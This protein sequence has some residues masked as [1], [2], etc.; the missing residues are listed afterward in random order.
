[1]S[2]SFAKGEICISVSHCCHWENFEGEKRVGLF[3]LYFKIGFFLG[4]ILNVSNG[5]EGEWQTFQVEWE[6]ILG[7]GQSFKE[8][9]VIN[10]QLI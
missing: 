4:R 5:G 1:M 3:L 6:T 8:C 7:K 10:I 9:F 2:S